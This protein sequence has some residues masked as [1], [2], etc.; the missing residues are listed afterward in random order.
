V[1]KL[2]DI[3]TMLVDAED[4]VSFGGVTAGCFL[5]THDNTTPQDRPGAARLNRDTF[6]QVAYADFPTVKQ[7]SVVTLNGTTRKVLRVEM[8]QDG[9]MLQ[10]WME[11]HIG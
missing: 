5:V 11:K 9:L 4:T 8:I 3:R 10:L 1:S 6:I 7:N 2:D